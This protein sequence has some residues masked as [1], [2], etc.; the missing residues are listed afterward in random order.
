MVVEGCHEPAVITGSAG[1]LAGE[2]PLSIAA[3][4]RHGCRRSES[5]SW[6]LEARSNEEF[7]SKLGAALQEADAGS[8]IHFLTRFVPVAALF[9]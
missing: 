6:P 8:Q 1:I 7:V 2:F 5:G 4:R 3:T 9:Y